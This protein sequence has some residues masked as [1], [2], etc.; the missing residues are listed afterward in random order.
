MSKKVKIITLITVAIVG[1]SL[2]TAADARERGK[3]RNNGYNAEVIIKGHNGAMYSPSRHERHVIQRPGRGH[4]V[5]DRRFHKR[6]KYKRK[7]RKLHRMRRL[8]NYYRYERPV[9]IITRPLYR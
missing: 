4:Y 2:A 3:N 6:L 9:I 8:N 5:N 7:M 1:L